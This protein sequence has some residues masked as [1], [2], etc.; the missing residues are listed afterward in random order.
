M[1]EVLLMYKYVC[2]YVF[3]CIYVHMYLYVH[4]HISALVWFRWSPTTSGLAADT[5]CLLN[6][7]ACT[8]ARK[9]DACYYVVLSVLK[10]IEFPIFFMMEL[11]HG[12]E[13][14]LMSPTP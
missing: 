4:T 10:Q 2:I 7:S 9:N 3:M 1:Y 11:H 12:P 5:Q 6:R 14:L 13:V 8:K